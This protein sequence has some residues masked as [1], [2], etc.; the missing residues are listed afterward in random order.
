MTATA[1]GSYATTAALKTLIGTTD[2]NDDTLIGLICDRVNMYI[3]SETRRVLAPIASTTYLYDGDGSSVL[4]LPL[5]V[6]KAPI[7]GIRAITLLEF[8]D[9]TGDT[10]STV[11]AGDY[12]LRDR[13]GMTGPYE[14][15]YMSDESSGDYSYFPRGFET[16]RLTATAGWDAI[17]DD[18][19]NVALSAAQR[20]WNGRQS[21]YQ[22]IEG[23][24]E[25]GRPLIAR[26]F[27]LPDFQSLLRYKLRDFR[28]V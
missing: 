4:F 7:G 15:L 24:G 25:P 28:H 11:T 19:T 14:R 21:G 18:I 13:V 2:S 20:A 26:F 9:Y 17:P 23:T 5:P 12:F 16:V 1:I 8:R 6:D 3:E 22:N 27:Q 10:F